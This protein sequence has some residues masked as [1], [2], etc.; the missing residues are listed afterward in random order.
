MAR[1]SRAWYIACRAGDLGRRPIRRTI[2]GMPIV[3]FRGAGG[4]PGALLD[5]CPH[6]NVPLSMGSVEQGL[7]QCGYHGWRF[8]RLLC[9]Q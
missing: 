4:S 9:Q 3:L 6:R 7:L 2:L 1:V 8:A 5:R